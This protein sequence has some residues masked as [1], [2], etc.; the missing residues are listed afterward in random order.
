MCVVSLRAEIINISHLGQSICSVCEFVCALGGAS[1]EAGR[2]CVCVVCVW[3]WGGGRVGG[4]RQAEGKANT[5]RP[6]VAHQACI[7]WLEPLPE[8]VDSPG[9]DAVACPQRAHSQWGQ[10][11]GTGETTGY[12]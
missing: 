8:A 5:R 2:M 7:R 3:S 9:E 1:R 6:G 4:R 10:E 11:S 12:Q